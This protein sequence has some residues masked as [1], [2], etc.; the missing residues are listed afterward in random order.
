MISYLVLLLFGIRRCCTR[1]TYDRNIDKRITQTD[2]MRNITCLGSSYDLQLPIRRGV[3]L[4]QY[5]M[6]QLCAKEAYGGAVVNQGGWCSAGLDI[7]IEDHDG[8]IQEHPDWDADPDLAAPTLT[9]V[10]FDLG[11]RWDVARIEE[12]NPRWMLGCLNR[13]FCN[14]GIENINI[15]PKRETPSNA[16][17][18]LIEAARWTRELQLDVA[19]INS[20]WIDEHFGRMRGAI[21]DVV[22]LIDLKEPVD[23]GENAVAPSDAFFEPWDLSLDPGNYITCEGEL[24]SFPLPPPYPVSDFQSPQQLCAVQ[25]SGGL[26]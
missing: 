7:T 22:R 10:S 25:W 4:N 14:W 17:A 18:T 24:P 3:D 5:T 16:D 21:V 9:G 20:T 15:Q 23:I 19:N 8:P 6:Q 26:S 2:P 13:C 11:D 1:S 12:F